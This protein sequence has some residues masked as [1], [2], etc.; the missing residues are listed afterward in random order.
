MYV[1]TVG[2][3]GYRAN[4]W[5][6]Q[7]ELLLWKRKEKGKHL[8]KATNCLA[9]KSTMTEDAMSYSEHHASSIKDRHLATRVGGGLASTPQLSCEL[10]LRM[11]CELQRFGQCLCDSRPLAWVFLD[12]TWVNLLILRWGFWNVFFGWLMIFTV[13]GRIMKIV[14][15]TISLEWILLIIGSWGWWTHGKEAF[16]SDPRSTHGSTTI[17]LLFFCLQSSVHTYCIMIYVHIHVLIFIVVSTLVFIITI[18]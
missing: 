17:C 10:N 13:F 8:G 2:R 6:K 14:K 1:R 12:A 4:V 16:Y 7:G 9:G 15:T 18:I 11:E 3:W 5:R